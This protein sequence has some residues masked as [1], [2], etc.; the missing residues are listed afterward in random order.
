M[1]LARARYLVSPRGRADLAA[2]GT[3]L[4]DLDLNRLASELRRSFPPAEA[5]ALAEQVT[6]RARARKRFGDDFAWLFTADGLEMMT[7]PAVAAR[8]A[9][10]LCR[11]GA[12]V[13]DLTC[14]LGGDLRA[15]EGASI[16][17]VG[18]ESDPVVALLAGANLTRAA[19]VR[20]NA[21]VPPFA[22]GGA[23]V[24]IDPSR[25]AGGDRRFDP[26]AF[27]PAWDVAVQLLRSGRAGVMKAPPGIEHRHLPADA[28]VEFVQLGRSLREAAIWCGAGT[29][30]GLRRAVLLPRGFELTSAAP[31]VAGEAA[32]PGLF[33][34][35][36]ESCV[37]RAGLVRHLA[38]TLG[39]RPLDQQ[40]AYLAGDAA[41]TSPFAATFEVLDAMPFSLAKVKVRLR[42]RAWSPV[43]IRRRAFPIE[44]DELRRLL[45]PVH[46]D[47]VAL[48]CTTIGGRKTIFIGR[49]LQPESERSEEETV[50]AHRQ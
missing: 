27:S 7:H 20:G 4:A 21:T 44:P 30:P 13:L 15:C 42:E 43:E 45:G 17:C 19:V 49:R 26:R 40:V 5:S 29:M 25:R 48:L 23:T 47:P 35:D 1:D 36:P 46:G 14:G 8:R 10:R 28:E 18:I 50:D 2:I 34:H 31:E 12:P 9:A 38:A 3:G 22:P 11:M 33:I 41:T 32:K 24:I 16:R 39:A 6:L 37:T